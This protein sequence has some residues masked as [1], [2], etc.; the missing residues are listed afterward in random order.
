M[1]LNGIK[2]CEIGALGY[3]DYDL[4]RKNYSINYAAIKRNAY[5]KRH[6]R[7]RHIKGTPAYYADQIL[8]N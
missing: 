5:K 7:Y 3:M 8:W 1:Y 2:I 6:D 4:Y